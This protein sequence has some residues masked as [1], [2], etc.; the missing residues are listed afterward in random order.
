MRNFSPDWRTDLGG[1]KNFHNGV[2]T[3]DCI[4]H[5]EATT[6]SAK[7]SHPSA[8]SREMEGKT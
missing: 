3:Y 7:L 8:R 6:Q 2:G 5:Y 4:R 1:Q